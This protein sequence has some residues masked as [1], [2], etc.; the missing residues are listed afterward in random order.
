MRPVN[1]SGDAVNGYRLTYLWTGVTV[2]RAAA[3]S[4]A[5]RTAQ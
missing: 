2:V 4:A 1:L 5:A 3:A